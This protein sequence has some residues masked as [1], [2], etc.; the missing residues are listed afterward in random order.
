M[1]VRGR[2][3]WIQIPAFPS[4]SLKPLRLVECHRVWIYFRGAVLHEGDQT[5]S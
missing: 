5:L 1:A 3:P 4:F 2:E